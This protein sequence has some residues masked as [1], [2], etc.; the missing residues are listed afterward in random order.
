M[1]DLLGNMGL[2]VF[3]KVPIVRAFRYRRERLAGLDEVRHD[4]AVGTNAAAAGPLGVASRRE[5]DQFE[6]NDCWQLR[7]KLTTS[8]YVCGIGGKPSREGEKGK[9]GDRIVDGPGCALGAQWGAGCEDGHGERLVWYLWAFWGC[10]YAPESDR[11]VAGISAGDMACIRSLSGL[12]SNKDAATHP[13]S[14]RSL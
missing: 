12:S 6:P 11:C 14:E 5:R 10:G 8:F 1:R 9:E 3:V 2:A 13:K 4:R 7:C